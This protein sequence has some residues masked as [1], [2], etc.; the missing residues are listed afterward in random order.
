[1]QDLSVLARASGL[2]FDD[3]LR[4]GEQVAAGMAQWW[5]G[6]VEELLAPLA[7]LAERSAPIQASEEGLQ[8]TA[9]LVRLDR[10]ED[11]DRLLAVVRD[12]APSGVEISALGPM[13]A[14][15]FLDD[16]DLMPQRSAPSR[17]G[18]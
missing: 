3:R 2:T 13:P 6:R 10:F 5:R 17:W 8:R 16:L 15:S 4:L 1:L 9:F 7:K 12:D 14:Y 18:W 11:I